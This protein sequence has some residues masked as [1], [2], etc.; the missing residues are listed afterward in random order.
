MMIPDITIMP[1]K[2]K[3]GLIEASRKLSGF[4]ILDDKSSSVIDK[5]DRIVENFCK[6]KISS[7]EIKQI[8]KNML[9]SRMMRGH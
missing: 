3:K 5:I 4:L 1:E 2:V 8:E 9:E 6:L 7:K